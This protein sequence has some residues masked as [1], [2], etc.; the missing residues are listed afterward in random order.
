[1]SRTSCSNFARAGMPLPN[2][3]PA[4]RKYTVSRYTIS[5]D[6]RQR[7]GTTYYLFVRP[8]V[9]VDNRKGR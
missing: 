6:L 8:L 9:F 1:M 2:F 3:P 5:R 4:A 7:S